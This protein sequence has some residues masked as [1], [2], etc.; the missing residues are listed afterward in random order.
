M[1]S[2]PRQTSV[3]SDHFL[4]AATLTTSRDEPM[5]RRE[6]VVAAARHPALGENLNGATGSRC[7]QSKH[8]GAEAGAAN[9]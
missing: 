7:M 8:R 9:M 6:L 2:L 3:C 5:R 1:R 4:A